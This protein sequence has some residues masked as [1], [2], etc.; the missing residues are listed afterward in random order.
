MPVGILTY[1]GLPY[2][3]LVVESVCCASSA[4]CRRA[5]LASAL[6][7]LETNRDRS[8]LPALLDALI[9]VSRAQDDEELTLSA[10]A[11][12]VLLPRWL[13]GT[14]SAQTC[15][16]W[17]RCG[18]CW[19]HPCRSEPSDGSSRAAPRNA[20]C[21]VASRRA[22]STAPPDSNWPSRWRRRPSRAVW[23]RSASGASSAGRRPSCS[24]AS[25]TR[26]GAAS[27]GTIARRRTAPPA[28]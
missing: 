21:C 4:R 20:R 28:G 23:H 14:A 18:R 26:P 17:R 24:P 8:R 10:W 19:R 5:T 25:P 9:E 7:A 16:G 1:G 22:S 11:E 12:Q 13:R 15:R 27:E 6:I 2:Q 3:E